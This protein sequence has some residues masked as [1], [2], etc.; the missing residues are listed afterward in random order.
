MNKQFIK[1][2]FILL[3]FILINY[4][5]SF[6]QT[7]FWEPT[8]GPANTEV[9]SIAISTSNVIWAGTN[10]GLFMSTNNGDTWIAKNNGLTSDLI[11]VGGQTGGT[12][13][14][15]RAIAIKNSNGFLFAGT[16]YG[17]F[18]S[19]DNG[20]NWVK[21]KSDLKVR[22]IL[23]TPSGGIY[24]GIEPITA[25]DTEAGVY[26][27]ND[28]GITW[29]KKNEG[30]YNLF[31]KSLAIT[32]GGIL[33]AGT[34]GSGVFRSTD[35]GDNWLIAPNNADVSVEAIT[36]SSDGT[37]YAA[38]NQPIRKGVLKSTDNGNTWVQ[39]NNGLDDLQVNAIIFN[40]STNHIFNGTFNLGVFRTTDA[41]SNWYKINNGLP[42]ISN[43]QNAVRVLS[44]NSSGI[45]FAGT[46]GSGV[47]RSKIFTTP[48]LYTDKDTIEFNASWGGALPA[49]KQFLVTNVGT[50]TLNW[51]ATKTATWFDI[52]PT[53][54]VNN[55]LVTVSINSTTSIAPG[56]YYQNITL[57]APNAG[58][59]SPKIVVV[60][61]TLLGPGINVTSNINFGDVMVGSYKD[62]T[63][64][65]TNTGTSTLIISGLSFSGTNASMFSIVGNPG[66]PINITAG[67]SRN[68]TIRFTPSSI[69]I[70]NARLTILHNVPLVDSSVVNLTGNGTKPLLSINPTLINFGNV[71]VNYSKDS[72]IN[73][74]SIGNANVNL[75]SF[76]LTGND[77]SSFSIT[78]PQLPYVISAGSVYNLPVRFLPNSIGVKN[79]ILII[80]HDAESSPDTV[81]LTGVGVQPQIKI[82][83]DTL[84]FGDVITGSFKVLPFTITNP[85]TAPLT[86]SSITKAGNDIAQFNRYSVPDSSS[87]PII[88]NPQSTITV[89]IRFSPISDGQKSSYWILNHNASGAQ[90]NLY[91]KGKGVTPNL[92]FNP[93]SEL[94]FGNVL[95]NSYKDS[96]V[97]IINNGTT[98]ASIL[99]ID[100]SGTNASEFTFSPI[101]LPKT[102]NPSEKLV[103][104]LRF[105]PLSL[106]NRT[107]NLKIK[108]SLTPDDYIINL[109]GNGVGKPDIGY[110]PNSLNFGNV[111]VNNISQK[112]IR[113]S[114]N[115]NAPLIIS[116]L[117]ISG[118]STFTLPNNETNII[119]DAG[120]TYD[121]YVQFLP[122][123]PIKYDATLSFSTNVN[124]NIITIPITGTGV[125]SSISINPNSLDFGDVLVG[126]TNTKSI[127]ITNNGTATLI[128]SALNII[129]TNSNQFNL[130]N[131]PSLPLNIEPN[132][133][134]DINVQFSPTSVGSKIAEL[135]I[136]HNA[137]TEPDKVSLSG[138]GV[139]PGIEIVPQNILDFGDVNVST[140]KNGF[141]TIKNTGTADLLISNLVISGTNASLFRRNSNPDSSTFLPITI[142]P[143]KEFTFTFTFTPN[144]VGQKNG[145]VSFITALGTY[146]IN[147]TGNGIAGDIEVS[148]NQIDFG[149]VV[150]NN[151]KDM[152]LTI[153]N[154]GNAPLSIS[155]FDITGS[156]FSM[157]QRISS[158]DSQSIQIVLNPGQKYTITLRFTPTSAG[159]KTANLKIVNSVN[160]INVSLIGKGITSG[161]S[162]QPT[163]LDFGN[164]RVG[165][166]KK[167]SI[168]IT[169]NGAATLIISEIKLLD[170]SNFIILNNPGNIN[171]LPSE[172]FYLTIQFA[173][174][175]VGLKTTTLEISHNAPGG[176]STAEIKGTGILP[177]IKVTPAGEMNF[178]DVNINTSKDLSLTIENTGTDTLSINSISISGINSS[179]F[180]L[181][182]GE[183]N[184][185]LLPSASRSITVRFTPNTVGSKTAQLTIVSNAQSSPNVIAL[186]GNGIVSNV[187]VSILKSYMVKPGNIVTISIQ[188]LDDL[189][190]KNAKT[191][192]L[193]L[194]YKKTI[195]LPKDVSLNGTIADGLTLSSSQ[196]KPGELNISVTNTSGKLLSGTGSLVNIV[197]QGLLGDT[198]GT[199]LILDSFSFN[200]DGPNAITDNGYCELIG[201]CG[202]ENAYVSTDNKN[203]LLQNIPNP[204]QA[205][206]QSFIKFKINVAGYTHLAI[207]D[208]LGREVMKIIDGNKP[209]GW[210]EVVVDTKNLPTG[211]YFYRLR[212]ANFDGLKKM[213]IIR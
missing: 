186:K 56:V 60:K 171:L 15:I 127:K 189:N 115:G 78:P 25:G 91:L 16:D 41:G 13:L 54:G 134:F 69:G 150:V 47:Y 194:K 141:I 111:N 110:E 205:G 211:V 135:S 210:H 168:R 57:T 64:T 195:L 43:G 183:N 39:V 67:N 99:N 32:S 188:A 7:N 79:A 12:P 105:L 49:S 45:M 167:D 80:N 75:N 202:G 156:D 180:N 152:Y 68:L 104:N 100:I 174:N 170:N 196:T 164:L 176:K 5:Y 4:H 108:N 179:L 3:I 89:W 154:K 138:K 197:F 151:S 83:P 58:T 17:L 59:S 42:P 98:S 158:P 162:L 159:S 1:S 122:V 125:S 112:Y 146:I 90:T 139:A 95:L 96:I 192:S 182:N 143:N 93:S 107:A 173:P 48:I 200:L 178:G 87:L 118:A 2:S 129:G 19:T 94:D 124:Q 82:S 55:N 37:I 109:K 70:K 86:I 24:I 165:R 163:T 74:S 144:T 33:L 30:L 128:I 120:K 126:L 85:G 148:T 40:P 190:G 71:I 6:S 175:S 92:L 116:Q 155:K 213:L 157:F 185:I 123:N 84:D 172:S 203:Y 209:E 76:I 181:P 199:Q 72:I 132:N 121:L 81:L 133:S 113:I 140:S 198:C 201:R 53:S 207:Y 149:N 130:L 31:V 52:N 14:L 66:L 46:L 21:V 136:S 160:D 11:G 106:G 103:I 10:S 77:A 101:T 73:I 208:L 20:D 51:S 184:F 8:S 102:L 147:L 117:V 35:N 29:V 9:W 153:S 22:A 204:V 44:V 26:F 166:T 212:T 36:I 114:N 38:T 206:S 191:F 119:I 137:S 65:I 145:A 61:Y 50:G 34:S 28:N 161:I 142:P 169:N 88:V 193:L 27:S 97:E 177:D 63:I 18:R 187:R 131:P 62:T 23:V